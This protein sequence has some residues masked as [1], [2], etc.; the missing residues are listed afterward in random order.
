MEKEVCIFF[1]YYI[2]CIY[3]DLYSKFGKYKKIDGDRFF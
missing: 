3:L 1:I 2:L